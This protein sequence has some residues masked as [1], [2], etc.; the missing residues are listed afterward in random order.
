LKLEAQSIITLAQQIDDQES[1][2]NALTVIDYTDEYQKAFTELVASWEQ[3]GLDHTSGLQGE[4]RAAAH[5]LS[6]NLKEH[7]IDSLQLA[8]LMMPPL[9][10]KRFYTHWQ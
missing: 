10:R 5:E 6:E 2:A 8:L 4:F 9:S 1:L 7:E 3:K